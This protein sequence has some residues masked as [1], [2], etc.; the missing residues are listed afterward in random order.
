MT[1]TKRYYIIA[2]DP[3]SNA[4]HFCKSASRNLKTHSS[5]MGTFSNGDTF[6]AVRASDNKVLSSVQYFAEHHEY[7]Y[8]HVDADAVFE[9]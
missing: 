4:P 7:R 6:F 3:F 5:I 2:C 8:V 1:K 9:W